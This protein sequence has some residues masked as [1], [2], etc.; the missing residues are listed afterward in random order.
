MLTEVRH[1]QLEALMVAVLIAAFATGCGAEVAQDGQQETSGDTSTVMVGFSGQAEEVMRGIVAGMGPDSL[2]KRVELVPPP[3]SQV[4]DGTPDV[5]DQSVYLRMTADYSGVETDR[6]RAHWQSSLILASFWRRMRD[7][8]TDVV[9]GGDLQFA[10]PNGLEPTPGLSGYIFQSD[11][12]DYLYK[13]GNDQPSKLEI[14][15]DEVERSAQRIA[16]SQHARVTRLAFLGATGS[17]VD[18]E[19]VADEPVRFIEA[20]LRGEAD[21]VQDP[22]DLEGL[23]LTVRDRAGDDVLVRAYA[24][25]LR[26]TVSGIGEK[27]RQ[28]D[29]RTKPPITL[30]SESE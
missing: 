21:I 15:R 30:T 24:T 17:A 10:G 19:L 8:G 18:V 5:N 1:G 14:D 16:A 25:G 9:W 27:Y 7:L 6:I 12:A 23:L 26:R 28:Y 4:T 20:W 22:G 2:I 11:A 3:A 29:P 13:N